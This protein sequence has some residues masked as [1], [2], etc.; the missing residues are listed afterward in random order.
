MDLCPVQQEFVK[1]DS[2]IH[3]HAAGNFLK[4]V[5]C[6][7]D[8]QPGDCHLAGNCPAGVKVLV[9]AQY[10]IVIFLSEVRLALSL[11]FVVQPAGG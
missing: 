1:G 11:S 8:V 4:L 7:V 3:R 10:C 5:V 2:H 9:E 6:L